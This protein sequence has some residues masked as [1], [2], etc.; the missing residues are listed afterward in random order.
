MGTA[1]IGGD[2]VHANQRAL[3]KWRE[4]YGDNLGIALTDTFGT[5]AFLQDFTPELARQFAGV[6]QDSGSAEEFV[7]RMVK[8]YR[9]QV[10]LPLTMIHI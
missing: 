9:Y 10:I 8:F 5:D 6:R 1:A 4:T 2:Y 7:E 3:T